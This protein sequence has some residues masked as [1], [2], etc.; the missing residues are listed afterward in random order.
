M[1][2]IYNCNQ[3]TFARQEQLSHNAYGN[4]ER[5]N[6]SSRKSRNSIVFKNF[7]ERLIFIKISPKPITKHISTKFCN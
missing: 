7:V 3:S 6:I 4:S 1:K 5:D 2:I